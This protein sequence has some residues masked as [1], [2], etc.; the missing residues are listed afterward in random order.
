MKKVVFFGTAVLMCLLFIR[1]ALPET[2][3]GN[4]QTAMEIPVPVPPQAH[5]RLLLLPKDL[6]ALKE[7]INSPEMQPAW[8]AIISNTQKDVDGTLPPREAAAN[9]NHEPKVLEIIES[10]ALLY[11][12]KDDQASGRKAIEMIQQYIN[13]LDFLPEEK[14]MYNKSIFSGETLY[15]GAKVYD[16]CYDLLSAEEKK[17]FI[18]LFEKLASQQEIGYPPDIKSAVSG[19]STGSLVLRNILSAG[20]AIYNEKQDMYHY[21]AGPIIED[22][23][24]VRNFLYQSHMSYHGDSYG[25]G[26]FEVDMLANLIFAKMGYKDVMTQNMGKVPYRYIYTRRPDGTLMREGDSYLNNRPWEPCETYWMNDPNIFLYTAAYYNNPYFKD[27]LMREIDAVNPVEFMLLNDPDLERKP[28]AQLPLSKYFPSPIGSMVARTSWDNW[29][30]NDK[31]YLNSNAVIAEM[32]VN[33]YH[34]NNHQ[35]LDDGAF[36]IYYKGGLITDSGVYEGAVSGYGEANDRNYHKRSIAHN[37][38]LIYDPE[39]KM[40]GMR[41]E[42]ANDGGMYWPNEGA[43]PK[44]I[45]E[46]LAKDYHTSTVLAHDFGP[47]PAQPEYTYLKGDHT[48]AY[49]GRAEKFQRS[50]VFLNLKNDQHP[51]AMIVFDHVA[52]TDKDF[53][54]Y[55][56]LHSVEE[57]SVNKNIATIAR[58]ERGYNGKVVNETLLPTPENTEIEKIGGPGKEFWVFGKNYP[59][60]PKRENSSSEGGAWRIQVSPKQASAQDYFLNVMQV[61]DHVGGPD[62]LT[63]QKIETGNRVGARIADRVVLFSK[64]STRT[65]ESFTITVKGTENSLK[66]V[67]TDLAAGGVECKEKW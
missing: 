1:S 66:Y 35:H 42:V 5:P 13:T 9:H 7:R 36:Q 38:M 2:Q 56:L 50:F 51:A 25:P 67:I 29:D 48:N 27:E 54:K 18:T 49:R 32:K 30:S 47:D 23:V 12:L 55:W 16:W 65:T 62:P 63:V 58:T 3:T 22:F 26:K 44:T 64:E 15:T 53:K 34:F 20:I 8:Q 24:P 41:G 46:L 33:E 17:V 14:A 6:P 11:L 37:T 19:H 60:P 4:A 28:H 57:P 21:A 59:N 39:Q 45:E 10:H 43:E 61:M 40:M 52:S 31:P